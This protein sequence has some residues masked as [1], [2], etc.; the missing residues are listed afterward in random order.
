M[1]VGKAN[2]WRFMA[3]AP[4]P[5]AARACRWAIEPRAPS[6]SSPR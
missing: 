5:S 3:G 4:A 1:V 6:C 2:R